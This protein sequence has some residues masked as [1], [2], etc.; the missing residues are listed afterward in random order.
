MTK[1]IGPKKITR[2]IVDVA[3]THDK[4]RL[5][6]ITEVSITGKAILTESELESMRN[7]TWLLTARN[8]SVYGSCVRI[9]CKH[10]Y[11]YIQ[12]NLN[13]FVNNALSL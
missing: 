9:L 8:N 10:Y 7:S 12:I 1:R 2:F 6:D 3:N 11:M 5:T 4:E 13:G